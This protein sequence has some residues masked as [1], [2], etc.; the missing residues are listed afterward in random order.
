[1]CLAMCQSNVAPKHEFS[2]SCQ[3]INSALELSRNRIKIDECIPPTTRNPESFLYV[4]R[5]RWLAASAH[6]EDTPVI[7]RHKNVAL[8]DLGQV[9]DT[10]KVPD[11]YCR[12]VCPD[13][14]R[15]PQCLAHRF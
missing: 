14:V 10:G 15:H 11:S 5:T 13:R 2:R 6:G 1:M 12:D 7:T 4:S 8:L 9:A 3:G